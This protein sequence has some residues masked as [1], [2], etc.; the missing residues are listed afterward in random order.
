MKIK[1][2]FIALLASASLMSCNDYLDV[3]SESQYNDKV[4]FSNTSLAEDA[5]ISLS[6]IHI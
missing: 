3:E 6:L 1:Y 2:V 4:V 5:V